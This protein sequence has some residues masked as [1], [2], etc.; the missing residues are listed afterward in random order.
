[1]SEQSLVKSTENKVAAPRTVR[2]WIATDSFKEQ[3]ALSLPKHLT[4]DRFTRIAL[5]AFNRTPKL[6]NCT[7][8]SVFQCLLDLSALGLE[9]DGR[10]AHLIPY[11]DKCQ[12]IIDYK[13][14]VDLVRR[15]GE[16]AYIHADVVCEHDEFDYAFGT[17]A[18]LKHKPNLKKRGAPKC[19]YS[20]VRLKDGAEDFD[21]MS[22]EDVDAVKRKS[23]SS[24]SGPWVDH[25]NEMAKKTVFRRHSK[26]LPL[27]SELHEKIEKDD[28]PLTEQERFNAARTVIA[29]VTIE[30]PAQPVIKEEKPALALEA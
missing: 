18:F 17:G 19:V 16:V 22:V 28:E 24:G 10:R 29:D 23:R 9:P 12:L 2:E 20:Y 3:V 6:G 30:E 8:E 15:S 7:K 11:G 4:P 21:V 14:I 27:S 26:W 5:T 13:G 25:W 1:M